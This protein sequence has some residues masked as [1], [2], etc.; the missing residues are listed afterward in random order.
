M[1]RPVILSVDDDPQVLS[2]IDRDLS[3]HY[4][5]DYRVVKA[6]SPREALDVARQ[7]KQRGTAS[8]ALPG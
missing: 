5:R 8:R 7:L 4:K 6:G 3:R 2:A 1:A